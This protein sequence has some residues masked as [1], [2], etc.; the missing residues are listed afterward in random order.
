MYNSIPTGNTVPNTL[1]KGVI[2]LCLT[3]LLFTV[4]NNVAVAQ[5]SYEM[6]G[7]PSFLNYFVALMSCPLFLMIAKFK[8]EDPLRTLSSEWR[9]R[10][11]GQAWV[12]HKQYGILALTTGINWISIQY[13][14]AWVD[15]NLQQ[16]MA[17]LTP[18]F[19][20]LLSVP[21]VR[22]SMGRKEA[23]A[24]L[25]VIT[26]VII[27]SYP[28]ISDMIE[29]NTSDSHPYWYN[30]WYFVLIFF[31]SVFFQSLEYVW[32]ERVYHEPYN[33]KEA[34]CLFWYQLYAVIP[35]LIASPIEMLP[36]ITG[37][38]E[39]HDFNWLL[40]NQAAAFR[41]FFGIPKDY[42][43]KKEG[44]I[45]YQCASY[46]AGWWVV[47]FVIGFVGTFYFNAILVKRTSAF[48]S[49]I[50][51][52]IASPLAAMVFSCKDIVGE[53]GYAKFTIYSGFGFFI[54]F[55]GV[56]LRG[57]PDVRHGIEKS[58]NRESNSLL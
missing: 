56:V 20:Y 5:M 35:Y 47:L 54:M 10:N 22:L 25:I 39:G 30:S 8:G 53:E 49:A 36:Q 13:V 48:W 17:G 11:P 38:E 58:K 19:V 42:E 15:G 32:Q 21:I 18:V 28:A 16:V 44:D 31:I 51:M 57:N 6:P 29:G 3:V 26:G 27:A 46:K 52:A 14:A 12:E 24:S 2:P 4:I 34:T 33:L 50:L 45:F 55:I 37:S 1:N 9:Q 41:C 23:S 7:F 40:D 43:I